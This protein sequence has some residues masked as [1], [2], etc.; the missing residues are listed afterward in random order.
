VNLPGTLVA[1]AIT[2]LAALAALA[3]WWSASWLVTGTPLADLG[4]AVNLAG[5]FAVLCLADWLLERF[6]RHH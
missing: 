1:P 4:L 2:I 5:V 6:G 3:A